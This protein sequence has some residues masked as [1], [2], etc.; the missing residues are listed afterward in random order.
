MT[1]DEFTSEESRTIQV[2]DRI[3]DLLLKEISFRFAV[4]NSGCLNNCLL[5]KH[6]V[7]HMEM[8]EK[9][10]QRPPARIIA[11]GCPDYDASD[12]FVPF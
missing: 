12:P 7:E 4:G 11:Y 1:Y 3:R 2:G 8:C 5:C 9:Y 10:G 6:F